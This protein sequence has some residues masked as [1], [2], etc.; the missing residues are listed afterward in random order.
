M[1]STTKCPAPERLRLLLEGVANDDLQTELTAHLDSCLDCRRALEEMASSGETM[2]AMARNLKVE[3]PAPD[4][5]LQE[6]I[7]KLQDD[8]HLAETVTNLGQGEAPSLDFLQP[9]QKPGHLGRFGE[10]EILEVVGRGGMGVVMKAHD[11]KLQRIVAIKAM[12][13]QLATSATARRRFQREAHSA[14]AVSH[15]HIVTIH[16]INEADGLPYIVMQYVGGESL[17]QRLDRVGPLELTEILRIGMQTASGLAAA[18]AQGL[19]HRDIKPANILL[20]NGIARVKITDFGLARAVD[21]ASVTQ[22]GVIAG[23]PMFMAPE[24][25]AGTPVDH[26]ADLFSLGSVLYALCTGHPPFRATGTMAVLKRVM[27][28]TPRPMRD[29]NPE[30]PDW[31]CDIVAK[32]HAKKPEDRFQSAREVAELLGQHLAHLQQPSQVA[33]LRAWNRRR[34][35]H[36]N[37]AGTESL[38]SDSSCLW[39]S[40]RFT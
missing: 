24:Q 5:P 29:V 21:D 7:H 16:E 20:E 23:T 2:A 10:F 32:L 9:S 17:Q 3:S 15:D 28:D 26:R 22:S 13:P 12:A 27:E 31:L 37:A 39:R 14:A 36:G 8:P 6:I 25:A 33:M 19:I 4:T 40:S 38:S 11:E 35:Q 34:R 18:H 30:I 1:S